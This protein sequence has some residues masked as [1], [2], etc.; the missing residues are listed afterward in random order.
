MTSWITT[1]QLLLR[2]GAKSFHTRN[3]ESAV[4][5]HPTANTGILWAQ[6]CITTG[7]KMFTS[8]PR[9]ANASWI[10]S[11]FSLTIIRCH[12]CPPLTDCSWRPT[13]CQMHYK[14]RIQRYH[15]LT[16]EMTPSRRSQHWRTF[17]N[18]NLK[19][20]HSHNSSSSCQFHSTHMPRRIIQSNLDL[21]RA[22]ATSNEIIDNNSRSRHNQRAITSEGGHT[23]DE[24]AF[25]SEGAKTLTKSCSP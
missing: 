1:K 13:T 16:S 25:T 4:L 19:S 7:V 15:S 22:P 24:S 5:R 18:S 2:R 21:S 12:S 8:R 14:T 17:S 6:Q 11:S 10:H 20:S 3:R 23:N 9:L